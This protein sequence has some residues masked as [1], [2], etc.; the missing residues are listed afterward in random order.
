M[1]EPIISQS[2]Y[3]YIIQID[4]EWLKYHNF[5]STVSLDGLQ[6]NIHRVERNDALK[7]IKPHEIDWEDF[8]TKISKCKE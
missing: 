5:T 1:R 8:M 3:G 2:P 7:T 4:K 6:Y